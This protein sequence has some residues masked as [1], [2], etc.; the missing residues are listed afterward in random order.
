MKYY[1][2]DEEEQAQLD[3]IESGQLRSVNDLAEAKHKAVRAAKSSLNKTLNINIRLSERDIYKLKAKAAEEG[4][5][6]QTF[7]ASILHKSATR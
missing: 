7:A 6:Y 1:E 3:D 5:P 4:L 2:L